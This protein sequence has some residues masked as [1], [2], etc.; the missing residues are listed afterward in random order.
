MEVGSAVSILQPYT[1]S[2]RDESRFKRSV[3]LSV[4]NQRIGSS[5]KLNT[6]QNL[7]LAGLEFRKRAEVVE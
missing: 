7:V 5:L 3:R 4:S 6:M 2:L 1:I